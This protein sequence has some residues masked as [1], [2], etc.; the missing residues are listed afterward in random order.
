MKFHLTE[1]GFKSNF[2]YGDLQISGDEEYGFRPFQLMV[3]S[4]VGCSGSVFRKILAKQRIEIENME[5]LAEVKRNPHEANRIEKII[6]QYIVQGEK[7]DQ[8]KLQK[9]L[10]IARKNCAM[11]QSV[12]GS[13]D[14]EE[15]IKIK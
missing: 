13:I 2:N 5:I 1:K 10:A 15:T 4:I 7:L 11:V 3:S 9:S 12:V 6:L 14:I 8:K